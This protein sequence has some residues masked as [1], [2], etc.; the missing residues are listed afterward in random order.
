MP[1]DIK[2]SETSTDAVTSDCAPVFWTKIVNSQL[3]YVES[4]AMVKLG[5]AK[6]RT[7]IPQLKKRLGRPPNGAPV[8]G[9]TKGVGAETRQS[10][11]DT[12]ISVFDEQGF[13]SVSMRQ[14]A[15]LADITPA[16]IYNY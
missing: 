14:I 1:L 7:E 2:R 4:S 6:Y 11:L 5:Q 10:I 12:A 16:S 13:E 3:N 15:T 9:K 8:N